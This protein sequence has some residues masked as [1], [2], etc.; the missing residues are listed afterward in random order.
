MLS[1]LQM[2]VTD[3]KQFHTLILKFFKCLCLLNAWIDFN[4]QYLLALMLDTRVCA[5]QSLLISVALRSR[6]H[7]FFTLNMLNFL[8][9]FL[10]YVF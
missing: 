1:D 3:L 6:S 8:L 9:K 7:T 10:I 4:S 2:K 5:V